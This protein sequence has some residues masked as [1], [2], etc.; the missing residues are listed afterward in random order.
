MCCDYQPERRAI[1]LEV[2]SG[3]DWTVLTDLVTTEEGKNWRSL[4]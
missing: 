2:V 4:K 1:D 3:D